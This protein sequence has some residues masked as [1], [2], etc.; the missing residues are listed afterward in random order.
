MH[1][2][3]PY[4]VM[5]GILKISNPIA[6]IRAFLDLF[7]ARPFGQSSLLQRMFSSG[8]QD[9]VREIQ[10]DMELVAEKV[11]RPA[12]IEKVQA[13]VD[14]P[15]AIQDMLY[16][17]AAS[18]KMDLMAV[19]L[20]S[21][22]APQ[23]SAADMQQVHRSNQAYLAYCR[24]KESTGDDSVAPDNEDA[25]LFE[26]L[27][28][29][30]RLAQRAR[31]KE[32]L[33]ELIFEGSTSELLKDIVTIFYQPLAQVY[34][35]A[36]IADSLS[37]LQAFLNDLIKTVEA[38]EQANVSDPQQTVQTF[39]DLVSRHEN[40]FYHFVYSV[41][42]KGSGLFDDLMHWIE[43]FIN[44]VREGFS[45]PV[46]L[47]FLLPHKGKQ[48]QEV[49]Q[50]IDAVVEYHRQLK[51]A[52][53]QRMQRRMV[54]GSLTQMEKDED[55]AFVEGVMQNLNLS[56]VT[57]DVVE[58]AAE[59]SEDEAGSESSDDDFQD[60]HETQDAAATS[61]RKPLK[62]KK[63][64]I[65]LVPPSLPHITEMVPV[66]VELLRPS[67]IASRETARAAA[68]ARAAA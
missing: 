32:Q 40:S 45:K 51:V 25:W 38:A 66:L 28:V 43:L 17:D 20:R 3:M 62:S 37:D 19:V 11:G 44:L 58:L 49:M 48:R 33:I 5:R 21:P 29:Y 60:A 14:A 36:N 16:A 41:H 26:D 46:A 64:R 4:F 50:E 59:E 27:H 39:V 57:E 47:E 23:L 61:R 65:V 54:R 30:L 13:F 24:K 53:H 68:S 12:V 22:E 10:E 67:L 52:H 9:E 55:M 56:S 31:D 6:M 34:R 42:S 2:L 7:L 35:A 63:D 1:G 8:L 18:E 15:K